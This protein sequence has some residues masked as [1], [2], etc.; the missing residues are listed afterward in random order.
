MAHSLSVLPDNVFTYHL[1]HLYQIQITT[2]LKLII[3]SHQVKGFQSQ[4]ELFPLPSFLNSATRVLSDN[5]LARVFSPHPRPGLCHIHRGMVS[6]LVSNESNL[7][8][9]RLIFLFKE[10]KQSQTT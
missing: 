4:L 7:D 8:V 3:P 2:L 5:S 9:D 10:K 1:F 6:H